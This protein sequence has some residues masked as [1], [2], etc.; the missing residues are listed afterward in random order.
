M[1]SLTITHIIQS[2]V[3]GPDADRVDADRFAAMVQSAIVGEFPD[4]DVTVR[5]TRGGSDHRTEIDGEIDG[6]DVDEIRATCR[7]AARLAWLDFG[8]GLQTA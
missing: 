4:A 2:D 1:T 3:L 7:E 5:V 8:R 6:V